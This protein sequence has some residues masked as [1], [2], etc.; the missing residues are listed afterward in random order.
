MWLVGEYVRVELSTPNGETRKAIVA[1]V[2]KQGD[3]LT[4]DL[5]LFETYGGV[6]E[7]LGTD[8]NNVL[9]SQLRPLLAWECVP[10]ID[11]SMNIDQLRSAGADLMKLRD[12]RGAIGTYKQILGQL[13]LGDFFIYRNPFDNMQIRVRRGSDDF[14]YIDPI[15]GGLVRSGGHQ[16]TV[17]EESSDFQVAVDVKMHATTMLNL[18]RA[19]WS[20]TPPDPDSEACFSYAIYLAALGN[21]SPLCAKSFFFRSKF[22]LHGRRWKAAYRDARNAVNIPNIDP[23]CLAECQQHERFARKKLEEDNRRLRQ[24]VGELMDLVSHDDD[25]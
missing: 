24:V 20:L 19:L 9:P 5:I 6:N 4:Y 25:P 12:W 2:N 11:G 21:E 16:I 1:D 23:L 15:N 22:R 17:I 18:G 10:R 8:L 13:D 7:T 3:F 14:G